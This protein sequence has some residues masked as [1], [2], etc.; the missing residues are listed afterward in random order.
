MAKYADLRGKGLLFLLCLWFLWFINFTSRM[1]FSPILPLIEDEF[2][3]NHAQ[4]SGIFV[5]LFA[6]YGVGVV[7][8]GLF[9]GTFGYK[10]SII[11]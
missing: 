11:Y 7:I 9:S 4:A 8:A 6:G 10:K 2:I 5:F 3:A 1:V